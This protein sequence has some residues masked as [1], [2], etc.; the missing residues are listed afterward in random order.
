MAL[1]YTSAYERDESRTAAAANRIDMGDVLLLAT[2]T[3]AVLAIAMAYAGRREAFELAELRR[4]GSPAVVNLNSVRNPS[5]L[6]PVLRT[7]LPEAADR[8]FA[9]H[10]LLEFLRANGDH[11]PT[12]GAI[13][14]ISIP[15]EAIEGTPH[16]V[17]YAERLRL[18]RERAA[19][20]HLDP[21]ASV[22]LLTTSD[23]AALKPILV[24]R[25]LDDFRATVATCAAVYVAAFGAIAVLWRLRRVH[26]DR[27]LLGTVH[28]LTAIGF[29][30]LVS[31]SDPIRDALLFVRYTE[32]I[33]IGCVV[34]GAVSIFSVRRALLRDLSYLPLTAA[35]MLAVLVVLFGDGPWPSDAKVNLG[36]VQPVEAI[37]LLL[38]L[39]LAGYFA[40][41][42]ELLRGLRA[43]SIQ[44]VHVPWWLN[45]PRVEY[46]IPVLAG[47]GAAACFFFLQ[48][49]LGPALLIACGFLAMYAV[50]RGGATLAAAGFAALIASFYVGY[51]LNISATLGDRVRMWQS[52]WNNG[53]RGGDQVAQAAWALATGGPTGVGLGLGDTRYL[54]AGYT[55][56][57][58]A[59]VGE[60]LGAIGL[61]VIAGAYALLAWRGLR[62]ARSATSD[63]E[64]FLA[65][66]LT[67]FL[68]IPTLIMTA[69]VLGVVPLTGVVTPFLSY[70]GSAMTANLAAVGMLSVIRTDNHAPARL[71]P[72]RVPVRCLTGTLAAC[73]AS[74]VAVLL[75]VQV[76]HA[77]D[78][79]VRAHLSL[80]A[81][82]VR[83]FQYNPRLVDIVRQI[84]RGTIYDRRGV[85]LATDNRNVI[86]RARSEYAR[87]GVSVDAA[88]RNQ[89]ARCYPLAGKAFHVLGDSGSRMNWSASNTSYVE[90]DAE[91]RL[92]GFDDRA[93]V[94]HTRNASGASSTVRR[95]YHDLLPLLR[96]RYEPEHPDVRAFLNRSRDVRLT[97]DARLQS[98]VAD[99]LANA[100]SRSATGRA[101]AVIIEPGTGDIL[102]V[103]SYPW[104]TTRASAAPGQQT[105]EDEALLDRARYG[106]YPPGSTFKLLTASAALRQD[107]SMSRAVFLCTRLPDGRVG[108]KIAG[109]NR[110][111]RDDVLD[112]RAHGAIGMHDGMVR[113]CNAYF[114]QLAMRLGPQPL[115]EVATPVGI[116]MAPANSLSRL[117][118]TLPEAGYGQGDVLATP[119]QMARVAAGFAAGGTIHETGVLPASSRRAEALLT[120]QAARVIAGYLRDAV[121]QGTARGLKDHAWRI[122]GKTGTAELTGAPSHAWFV[123][124][125]PYGPATRRIAMAVLVESAGYGGL[126]A[127]PVA[128]EI[129]TEAAAAGLVQ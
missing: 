9:A 125:A 23:L 67:L 56:L 54:P 68:V 123:G 38:A 89:A 102:A 119:M 50:A 69:G 121:L 36:P 62:I 77:D 11:L 116:T 72:F 44:S 90:R 17:V 26:G 81:D 32:G 106:L 80:Q 43:Q 79:A 70:G 115:L 31:R 120:P 98:R 114:G 7:V 21:P 107:P 12:V 113:S 84:P 37:R 40:R 93:T 55:D 1:A 128:G 73:A 47:V 25:T 20:T 39:F 24:V 65:T 78:Y 94:V 87:I 41:R 76:V 82:G 109:R 86:L 110:P 129:V 99:I 10:Y 95:D 53:I 13:L 101:A 105:V 111:I 117:R 51:Q 103:A 104:P 30:L 42:W 126:A 127:A 45:V 83:R 22:R 118:E 112:L 61:L 64:F 34:M 28:L 3:V 57:M 46:V 48:R 29:A 16:L 97:I 92:R 6:D 85:P 19:A 15:S 124:F 100:A 122:A 75:N 71:E 14:G 2:S 91:D 27:F 74:L 63:Y 66:S 35:L 18:A 108:A 49:D 52:P 8:N 96:H 5:Q 88:C 33:L 58:L 59:A 4:A 60:E